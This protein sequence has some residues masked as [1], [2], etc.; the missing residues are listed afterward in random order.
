MESHL[1]NMIPEGKT[2]VY[3]VSQN[4]ANRE[5]EVD[6]HDGPLS[7]TLDGS[8]ALSLRYLKSNG[9]FSSFPVTNTGGHKVT[10]VIPS[11]L[12]D[13]EGVVYCKLRVNGIGAKA[14]LIAVEKE[15]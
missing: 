11:D 8:E 13:N 4:D 14:F 6:L 7:V 1:I 3:H 15:T 5:I 10:V 2:K 12:T 9:V